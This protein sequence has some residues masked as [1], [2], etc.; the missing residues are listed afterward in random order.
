MACFACVAELLGKW[1]SE[2]LCMVADM[3]LGRSVLSPLQG[4][5]ASQRLTRLSFHNQLRFPSREMLYFLVALVHINTSP[6]GWALGTV[7][8]SLL[9][10]PPFHNT[11]PV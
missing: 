11:V 5:S 9:K 4:H 3:D 6:M 10:M 7:V 1:L 8:K 2:A